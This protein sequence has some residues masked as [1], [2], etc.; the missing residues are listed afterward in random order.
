VVTFAIRK[1]FQTATGT[2]ARWEPECYGNFGP[3]SFKI[4]RVKYY[5]ACSVMECRTGF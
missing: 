2:P 5:V 3:H 1:Q 4:F